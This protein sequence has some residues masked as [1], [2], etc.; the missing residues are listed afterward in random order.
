MQG[1]SK[2]PL[3]S[4][5]DIDEVEELHD[6]KQEPEDPQ[7]A[8]AAASQARRYNTRQRRVVQHSEPDEP[9]EPAEPS[10]PAEPE[11]HVVP[12]DAPYFVPE[13]NGSEYRDDTDAGNEDKQDT[14]DDDPEV[15]LKELEDLQKDQKSPGS[16]R[17]FQDPV[18]NIYTL[19]A[20]MAARWKERLDEEPLSKAARRQLLR[21][22]QYDHKRQPP[23][24][25]LHKSSIRSQDLRRIVFETVPS[26]EQANLEALWMSTFLSNE[27][28]A[29][30]RDDDLQRGLHRLFRLLQDNARQLAKFRR[31]QV[32]R[33]MKLHEHM[34]KGHQVDQEVMLTAEDVKSARERRA[35][36]TGTWR[37]AASSFPAASSS[38]P[39]NRN[40]FTKAGT[41]S[42][43][44]FRG[45][46]GTFSSQPNQQQR[47]R[48]NRFAKGGAPANR[49]PQANRN[50]E[51]V[52]N[53]GENEERPRAV[54]NP[55]GQRS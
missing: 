11:S 20:T 12:E 23:K 9:A 10:E 27:L 48:F 7:P 22:F 18:A 47:P 39:A 5:N 52:N 49:A 30:I 28:E 35:L 24:I 41:A 36:T 43:S 16:P 54:Y 6:A 31:D 37:R 13:E 32:L 51:R 45:Y 4:I 3:P 42:S 38:P 8:V 55:R 46:R 1:D 14:T 26:F 44:S 29:G 15:I 19:S 25:D 2:Y 34:D 40:A 33:I 17:I 50:N 53:S 21:G